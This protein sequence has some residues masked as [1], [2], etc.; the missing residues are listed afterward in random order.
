MAFSKACRTRAVFGTV[1][2][3]RHSALQPSHLYSKTLSAYQVR[4][5]IYNNADMA[6][7]RNGLPWEGFALTR[8]GSFDPP[9]RASRTKAMEEPLE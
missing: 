2:T 3:V 7:I 9:W 4:F 5:V 8:S 1:L 6:Y